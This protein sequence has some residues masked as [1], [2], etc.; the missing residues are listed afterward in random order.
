[1]K[2]TY[3]SP[4]CRARKMAVEEALLGGMSEGNGNFT[5]QPDRDGEG[6]EWE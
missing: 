6:E 2:K 4:E 1:M 3:I 5:G